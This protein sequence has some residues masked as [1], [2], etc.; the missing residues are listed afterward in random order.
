MAIITRRDRYVKHVA[1]SFVLRGRRQLGET[2]FTCHRWIGFTCG[3][4]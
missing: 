1:G 2:R 3:A 4:V